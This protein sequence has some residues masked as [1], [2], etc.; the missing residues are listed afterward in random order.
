MSIDTVI[1]HIRAK[2]H[3][4]LADLTAGKLALCFCGLCLIFLLAE[5]IRKKE[6]TLRLLLYD[7]ALCAYLTAI[8]S[9]TLVGRRGSASQDGAVFAFFENLLDGT[10]IDYYDV[11]F[12]TILFIPLGL[13]LGLHNPTGHAGL[14]TLLCSLAVETLQLLSARGRFEASDLLFNTIGGCFG[15]C[16]AGGWRRLNERR[17]ER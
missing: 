10:R 13:L 12:N 14:L 16:I 2:A 5:S 1:A 9:V 11:A 8:L 6:K 15:A 17:R 7:L 3:Y 4:Y